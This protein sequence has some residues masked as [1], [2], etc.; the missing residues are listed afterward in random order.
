MGAYFVSHPAEEKRA[1][2]WLTD[3]RR[4]GVG[5]HEVR[6]QVED[7]CRAVSTLVSRV[8][9]AEWLCATFTLTPEQLARAAKAPPFDESFRPPSLSWPQ[10]DLPPPQRAETQA[11]ALPMPSPESAAIAAELE[12]I[13]EDELVTEL[14]MLL[15]EEP[16]PAAPRRRDASGSR[17]GVQRVRWS[18]RSPSNDGL[19]RCAATADSIY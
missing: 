8:Y 9:P 4:R 1:F 6:K 17:D 10:V 14:A 7:Y 15:R 19:D 11:A 18:T 13:G 16:E 12:T 5:W 3:L 2:E